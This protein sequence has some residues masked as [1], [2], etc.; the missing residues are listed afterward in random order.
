MSMIVSPDSGYAKEMWKYEHYEDESRGSD[1][2]PND[3]KVF[4]LRPRGYKPYPAMM[5]RA[6]SKNP[7]K[8]ESETVNS[9]DEQRNLESRGFV[10]GGQGAAAAEYD[11]ASQKL[12]VEA[13]ER[14]YRDRNMSE[15]ALAESSAAEQESS[16]HLGE[17]PETP[18]RRRG[19][20][21]AAATVNA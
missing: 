13:A 4:G 15:N 20:K 21:P 14:N 18:I 5:Y 12:A 19:R 8:F 6:V 7:W 10:A 11:N 2:T 17:I 9:L 3:P 16:R 1:K